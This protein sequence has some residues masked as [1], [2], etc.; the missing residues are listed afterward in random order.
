MSVRSVGP[1][2]GEGVPASNRGH[3]LA[4]RDENVIGAAAALAGAPH[5]RAARGALGIGPAS[6]TGARSGKVAVTRSSPPS[7]S[8]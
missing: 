8:T 1:A 6:S 4:L 3:G 5:P 7:A 2:P